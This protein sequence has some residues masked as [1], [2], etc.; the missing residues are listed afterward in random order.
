[1]T[2]FSHRTTTSITS[3]AAVFALL[4]P[5]SAHADQSFSDVPESHYAHKAIE[6]LKKNGV[7]NGYEDGTFQPNKAVNRAEAI[8]MITGPLIDQDQLALVTG[9]PFDDVPDGA[10]YLPYVEAA[11]Q[12]NII[13]G[14]PKK[15]SFLGSNQVLKAE[16]IKMLIRAYQED[17]NSYSEIRLPFSTDVS[18]AD[19]WFYPY[20]RFALSSSMTT[21]NTSGVL[22]PGK[23]LTRAE[24]AE[25][26]YRLIQYKQGN[27][28]QD[29]LTNAE[30]EIIV[31]LGMLDQNNL[32]AAQHASARALIAARG[33]LTSKPDSNLVKGA[34]K[35]T[36][37]FRSVVRAYQEGAS[38][39]FAE[40]VRL[41]GESWNLGAK[42]QEFDPS[43]AKLA[44]QVQSISK[45]MADGARNQLEGGSES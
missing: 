30:N 44:E 38:G 20:M 28:T 3:I 31:T 1:M 33:A 22:Q 7:I 39:N 43:M 45:Q 10:W 17:E 35:I 15:T 41:S 32:T 18:N 11:R 29:L 16:Y 42:A 5:I 4:L 14:P 2:L 36:E 37:A 6:F 21:I 25:M 9:T 23:K 34:L 26:L 24:T 12:N 8:K 13:D 19:D 27:R 40:V